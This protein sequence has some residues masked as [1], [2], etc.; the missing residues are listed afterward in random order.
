[1]N[2]DLYVL[3]GKEPRQAHSVIEWMRW[4]ADAQRLIARTLIGGNLEV[5]TMFLAV[6]PKDG[7]GDGQPPALFETTAFIGGFSFDA[8]RLLRSHTWSEAEA[9]HAFIAKQ[10]QEAASSSF[11]S[12][13][14]VALIA[15]DVWLDRRGE[16][17]H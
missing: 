12:C 6:A 7:R 3:D 2:R 9:A 16:P 15:R 11:E 8:V 10:M 17:S 5:V 4:Y 13:R 14:S 1:M